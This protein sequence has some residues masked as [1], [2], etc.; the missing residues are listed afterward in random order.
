MQGFR[1]IHIKLNRLN[2]LLIAL[3]CTL[4]N[5][6]IA[7]PTQLGTQTVNGTYTSYSL[8]DLGIFRQARIQAASSA[9]TGTRNWEFYEA[10][11]DYD[12]AWR[13]YTG[14][15]TLAGYNMN[16][17]PT[18]GTA[19]ALFNTGFGGSAGLMPTIANGYYYTFN[20]TE[21]STPGVP[22]NE[23]MGV[24][25]TSY[26]PVGIT[27]VTQSPP[28][29][30][31]YPENSVYVTVV[32]AAAPSP[33]ENVFVRYSTTSNFL[34]STLLTVTMVGST[35]TVEIPCQTSGTTIYYY[36]YTSSRTSVAIL[37]DVGVT[38]ERAHDMSTLNVNNNGGPN[39]T[40]TVLPSIGF[41]GNYYVP[42]VCYPTIASFVT[43]LNAGSVS[44]DVVCNVAAGHTETAPVN[45]I[46][47]TQTGTAA[48]TITF[49]KNGVGA[50]PI[51]YAQVGTVTMDATDLFSDGIF[52]INGGDYITIDAIDL[53]DNN[54]SGAAMMEYGYAFF[55]PSNTNGCSNNIIR[56]CTINLQNT[57]YW[58]SAPTNFEFG[59]VGIFMRNSTRTALTTLHVITTA[60]GRSDDNQFYS[61]QIFGA[62]NGIVIAGY[63]D[64]VSP[65]T[66]Y[67]RNNSVGIAG[68]GNTIHKWG[69]NIGTSRAIG[70]FATYNDLLVIRD[71][72]ISN[73]ASGG[74]PH[75]NTLYGI[76]I[77]GQI[78][79]N[80]FQD[81]AIL[82]NTISLQLN[83][84]SSNMTGIRVGTS[85][86][87]GTSVA[88][89]GNTIQ[90]CSYAAASTSAFL[91]ID[92]QLNAT[93]VEIEDNIIQNNILNS[94]T[95]S[96]SYLI[97]NNVTSATVSIKNNQLLNNSKTS[98]LVGATGGFYGYYHA[99]ASATGT[100]TFE[101]NIIDGLSVNSASPSYTVGARITGTTA[102][103]KNVNNNQIS[104]IVGG[105]SA[106]AYTTALN[107]DFMPSGST[108]NGNTI[109]NISS[110]G[111]SIGIN[112][113]TVN[114]VSSS[115]NQTYTISGNT[116][117]NVSSTNAASHIVGI[118]A[119]S[120]TAL[121]C[122]NNAIDGVTSNGTAP[123]NI[124]GLRIGG[125]AALNT[126][127]IYNNEVLNVLHNNVAT[128]SNP[129]GIY[130]FNNSNTVNVYNNH[131]SDISGLASET[132]IGIYVTSGTGIQQIYNNYVQR[133]SAPNSTN[134][135][136]VSGIYVAAGGNTYRVYNNTVALGFEG[137]L[138]G[139]S[140]FGVTGFYHGAGLLDLRNNI[141]YVNANAAGTG[142]ASCLRKPTPGAAGTAPATPSIA[143]TTNNNFY[144][145]NMAANNYVYVEGL[146][147]AAAKNGYAYGGA[148]TSV[149]NNLNNDP[150]F[151]IL[152]AGDIMSYK[153]F[154]SL[155]GG[156]TREVNSFY[157]VPNFVGGATYP[158]NLKITVGATDYAESHATAI[159]TP[160]ITTDY[161]GNIRFGN[162]GYVGTGTAPDIGA[163][164]GEF[165]LA[166]PAC[167]LLPIE[168]ITFTGWNN[169]LS[170]ELHWTT[171]TE[172]NSD[173]FE[174][175]RSLNGID[176]TA[177]GTSDAA[178]NSLI[179]LNYIFYDDAP[180]AG[181]NYYRLKMVD[182]DGA[183]DYSNIIAIRLANTNGDIS[184]YP[185]PATDNISIEFNALSTGTLTCNLLDVTG[186]K[187][188][189]F[190]EQVNEG[191][192]IFN[193][194]IA[195][196]PTSTYLLQFTNP[197]T[198]EING[199]KLL[200]Y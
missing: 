132:V 179:P 112:C 200:K 189:Q 161:E 119:H 45:G 140:G 31:V 62:F 85:P 37:S 185:N 177:I 130:L 145:L 113:G 102:Q 69:Y 122:F 89:R 109:S 86:A 134:N 175:Q 129:T 18:A 51:I 79:F 5:Y 60:Q 75:N 193:Y 26:N 96:V 9:P 8:T 101:D 184:I 49:I 27:S 84:I 95:T 92:Q 105:T 57:N 115:S 35:G 125:G 196:L 13:P 190:T 21:Y 192:N 93:T 3:L 183:Y 82:D 47:L 67:D 181:I 64:L 80:Y 56:N 61:N 111:P 44:C 195:H 87:G 107:I 72:D 168:L 52:S 76:F 169:G 103:I 156:G 121:N 187:V 165:V 152:T 94:S 25:E 11:F 97:Y 164:E 146:T 88:I 144:Y 100:V 108:V 127:N 20:I 74:V 126:F 23:Y 2:R 110:A 123:L 118:Y 104:N 198:G 68:A 30:A 29:G 142:L 194:S 34:S 137:T 148:T 46:N 147:V 71:N 58:T 40:Y 7:Q 154:M 70:V 162:P 32:T 180:Y 128:N 163:D 36:V 50:N 53:I 55:K 98:A 131:V 136:S 117:D 149:L 28:S 199:I 16:I 150:C 73:Y 139:G 10:P 22:Q 38:G 124:N 143:A 41:C 15:L 42:S 141:I 91:A 106:T 166:T 19:S 43:A 138:S 170:N 114:S 188:M 167:F 182:I 6:A 78:T 54:V 135:L 81:F 172:I 63:N 178:G 191:I 33:G 159:A 120:L 151:N 4:S 153:Y 174:I 65:Y 157:D 197:N 116:V 186:R 77:S 83:G 171:A 1:H 39:Y 17:F 160:A 14:G 155:S 176:F 24:V 48:K 90:D 99:S 66:Y 173:Y 133:L 59:S 158:N 12:P